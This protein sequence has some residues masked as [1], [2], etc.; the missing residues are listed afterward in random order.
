MGKWGTFF[1][2]DWHSPS[3]FLLPPCRTLLALPYTVIPG[4]TTPLATAPRQVAGVAMRCNALL[5]LLPGR[6]GAASSYSLFAD[7]V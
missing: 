5:R 7:C 4:R 3:F 2:R 6:L 1:L